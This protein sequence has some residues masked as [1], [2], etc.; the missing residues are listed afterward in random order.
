MAKPFNLQPLLDLMQTRADEK[1]R[2]LGQLISAEQNAK[3]RLQLLEQY[4]EEYAQKMREA[5]SQGLTPMALRNYQDFIGRIDEAIQQ[6][7]QV[8]ARSEQNTAAGQAEWR[9]QNKKLKAIDT[10]SQR[11][12]A[13]ERYRENRQ[14]QKLMDEFTARKFGTKSEE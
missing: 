14:D 13:R 8:V 5:I 9:E 7:G 2:Q 3:S 1:T 6:Q 4:R 10:L 11:H 12:D